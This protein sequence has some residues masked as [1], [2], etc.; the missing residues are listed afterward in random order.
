MPADAL[1]GDLNSTIAAAVNARVEAAVVAA[2]SGDEVIGQYVSA[3]LNEPISR[4]SFSRKATPFLTSIVKD[5]IQK[6]T[7]AAVEELVAEERPRIV[8][9]VKKALRR[10][11]PE[12]AERLVDGMRMARYSIEVRVAE[13]DQ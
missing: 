12:V 9:E 10:N 1:T 4:D 11:L 8:D 13:D 2:L 7:R 3:A 5:A 6:A